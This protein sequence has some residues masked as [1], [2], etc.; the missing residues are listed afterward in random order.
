MFGDTHATHLTGLI[1]QAQEDD[2]R[3]LQ[4]QEVIDVRAAHRRMAGDRGLMRD[5]AEYFVR[6]A[7]KLLERI[8]AALQSER[9]AD[10]A[11]AAHS[12]K[13]LAANFDGFIAQE[14]A[15]RVEHHA[16]EGEIHEALSLMEDLVARVDRVS[17][18]LQTLVLDAE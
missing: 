16:R 13:G 14:A 6:D 5:M 1:S 2:S 11:R 3:M 9:A 8:H 7:P 18:A 4:D 12:L 15:A 17:A 10:A